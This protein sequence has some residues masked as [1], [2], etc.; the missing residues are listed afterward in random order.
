METIGNMDLKDLEG[1]KSYLIAVAAAMYA[2]GGVAAGYHGWPYALTVLLSA[3]GLGSMAAKINRIFNEEV[4]PVVE[5]VECYCVTYLRERL[6]VNI[7]GDASTIIPNTDKPIIG[8]V[9]LF[10]YDHASRIKL[11]LLDRL[12]VEESNYEKCTPTER[13]IMKEDKDIRGYYYKNPN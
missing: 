4:E 9:V 11:I 7:R 10:K 8:G 1:K 6:G 3:G 5:K 2:L 12:I 13:V